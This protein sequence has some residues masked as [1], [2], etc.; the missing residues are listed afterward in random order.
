MKHFIICLLILPI[1][2]SGYSQTILYKQESSVL[3]PPFKDQEISFFHQFPSDNSHVRSR[4]NSYGL[5]RLDSMITYTSSGQIHSMYQWIYSDDIVP[6]ERILFNYIDGDIRTPTGKRSKIYS[7]NKLLSTEYYMEWL[8][9]QQ[10]WDTL[11]KEVYYYDNTGAL[12]KIQ[13][14]LAP[15]WYLYL[16]RVFTYAPAGLPESEIIYRKPDNG[17]AFKIDY[18]YQNGLLSK[19]NTYEWSAGNWF[20]IHQ[21]LYTYNEYEN[22][23]EQ[24][25]LHRELSS[26]N[27]LV[28]YKKALLKY[29]HSV[30]KDMLI[31]D[32]GF[33]FNHKLTEITNMEYQ[34]LTGQWILTN[35]TIPYYSEIN[36]P[37]TDL[38]VTNQHLLFDIYP[39][40]FNNTITIATGSYSSV[41]LE[42]FNPLGTRII[43]SYID[44]HQT[45]STD[46]LPIGTYIGVL[47]TSK[48]KIFKRLIKNN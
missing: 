26:G 25:F 34:R 3:L 37:V 35:I 40:P 46:Q 44:D 31:M 13:S 33:P 17:P 6:S 36:N 1:L 24:L 10:K 7:A 22:P 15:D 8:P 43:S 32:I 2:N 30:T 14:H 9:D 16:Q 20:H 39:N 11:T 42:V 38:R 45:L 18:I 29:D 41:L 48:G 27:E 47:H 28:A 21:V 5:F 12:T 19:E 23:V 4:L